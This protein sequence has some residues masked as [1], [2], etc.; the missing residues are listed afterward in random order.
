MASS[1]WDLCL[2][3]WG[4]LDAFPSGNP[5]DERFEE[6]YVCQQAR[7]EALSRWLSTQAA[8]IVKEE[9]LAANSKVSS[10]NAAFTP[11]PLFSDLSD[12]MLC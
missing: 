4:D 8:G 1:V 10:L 3:L 9:V 5:A 6:S 12:V 7:R 11:R 2:A